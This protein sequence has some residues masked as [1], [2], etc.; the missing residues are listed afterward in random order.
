MRH[1]TTHLANQTYSKLESLTDFKY[2][3]FMKSRKDSILGA[4]LVIL[5]ALTNFNNIAIDGTWIM[6]TVGIV[7]IITSL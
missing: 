7:L 1:T 6:T 2:N 4:L 3:F 5:G